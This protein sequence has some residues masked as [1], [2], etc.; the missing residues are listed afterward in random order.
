MI[1]APEMQSGSTRQRSLL[2]LHHV[3]KHFGGVKALN[4]VSCEVQQG[5]IF[6]VIGPNG[7]GKSTLLSLISGAQHPSSGEILFAGQ[8][9]E[10]L[11]PHAIAHLGIG[12]AH[13]IPRP[14]GRMT[15]QQNVLVPTHP[16]QRGG[17]V[18]PG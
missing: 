7:A 8:R 1:V 16:H 9:L 2:V 3:S 12:R 17:T 5:E 13:Q 10:R 15:V 6:G 14:F 11:P 4:D 18:A